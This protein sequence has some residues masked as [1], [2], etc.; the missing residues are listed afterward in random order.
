MYSILSPLIQTNKNKEYI[1]INISIIITIY[2]LITNPD[3]NNNYIHHLL[4][5]IF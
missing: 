5:S 3:I 1:I 2:F 4:S